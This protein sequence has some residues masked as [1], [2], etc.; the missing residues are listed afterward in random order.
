MSWTTY[1]SSGVALERSL[2]DTP[3]GTIVGYAG[4]SA[5]NGWLLCNGA[6][7]STTAYPELFAVIGYTYGGSGASFN[8]PNTSNYI[9]YAQSVSARIDSVTPPQY[10]TSLPTAPVNGQEIYYAADVTNGVI[11][12]LRYNGTSS[13]SYKWEFIGGSDLRTFDNAESGPVSSPSPAAW[14]N[15]NTAIS[16]TVPLA[17]DYRYS[18]ASNINVASAGNTYLGVATTASGT[19]TTS[20]QV[21]VTATTYGQSAVSG[22]LTGVSASSALTLRYYFAVTAA[23]VYRRAASLVVTP[24]RVG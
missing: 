18:A 20:N 24:V 9:I 23:N 17:G 11:W 10:V 16:V 2:S 12:H 15:I 8:V 14:T 7:Y 19:P 13:S 4:A 5:P 21:Y 1:D 3:V 6:S 22:T